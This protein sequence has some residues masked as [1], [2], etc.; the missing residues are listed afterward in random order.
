ML[1]GAGTGEATCGILDLASYLRQHDVEC[2]VQL[3]DHGETRQA[4]LN[5]LEPLIAHLK[6]KLVGISLKWFHH[7]SRAL[8]IAKSIRAIDPDIEICIGGNTASYYWRELSAHPD[9]DHVVLGD[10][11]VPLLALCRGEEDP[12]NVV[13]R[14]ATFKPQLSYIQSAKAD[15]SYSHFD[16]IFLSQADLASF[17]GWVA[18]GRGC[19]ENC[20]YCGG[21]RGMQKATFGRAKPFL[22]TESSVQRD[23]REIVGRT[24]QLRYDFS[25]SSAAFLERAWGGVD[26]SKHSTTYFLWGIP[27]PA[28]V[29]TLATAFQRVFMVI[30]I[31][32]FSERQRLEQM[33]RGLLKPCPTD[34]ALFEVIENTKRY[35]NLELEI[36]GI[37]GLPFA[38][39]ETLQEERGL[40]RQLLGQAC[41]IGYQRLEAQPGA[42]VTEHP[43]HFGML[44]EAKSY[45][46]FLDYFDR[47]PPGDASV[48]MIRYEAD[49]LEAAVQQTADELDQTIWEHAAKRRAVKIDG[50]T[51]LK[52]TSPSTRTVSL[53]Q[54]LG[55]HR[56]PAKLQNTEVTAIRSVDGVGMACAPTIRQTIDD[57][58]QTGRE[59]AALL[60]VLSLFA[61]PTSVTEALTKLGRSRLPADELIHHLVEGRFLQ[62]V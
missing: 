32:C 9:I 30:D 36:S 16:Q 3:T 33:R 31:G 21:T 55:A 8:L 25:G 23:H 61:K 35:P 11:E 20:L 10:G 48:P 37:A 26:L 45:H 44:S 7:L 12:P 5:T 34:S 39:V 22:R 13:K 53:G 2:F 43:E 46:D 27:D 15:S 42:L 58:L 56:V 24:W 62:P 49:A 51:R 4:L 18:P 1:I 50:R 19:G 28:L 6:P 40:I 41:A 54:W 14:G 17:S 47:R 59:A 57:S 60:E 29:E 38:S 52:N